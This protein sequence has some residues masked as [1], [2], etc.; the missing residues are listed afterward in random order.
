MGRI[1]L[2]AA[3][4]YGF[5]APAFDSHRPQPLDRMLREYRAAVDAALHDT[6]RVLTLFDDV[7]SMRYLAPLMRR[8]DRAL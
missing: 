5:G 1:L 3:A 4:L 2:V 8:L 7:R 6:R